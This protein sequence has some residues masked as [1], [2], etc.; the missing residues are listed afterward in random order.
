M[1]KWIQKVRIRL[2]QQ[3]HLKR[4]EMSEHRSK[5]VQE[6]WLEEDQQVELHNSNPKFSG[7]HWNHVVKYSMTGL[8]L[9]STIL[10][11]ATNFSNAPMKAAARDFLTTRNSRDTCLFTQVKNHI[12]VISVTRGSLLILTS[13]LIWESILAKSLSYVLIQT[14]QKGSIRNLIFMLTN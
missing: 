4:P 5:S 2:L 12:N 14:A 3:I 11:T 10:S 6:E 7:V 9:R 1:R 13:R 8:L